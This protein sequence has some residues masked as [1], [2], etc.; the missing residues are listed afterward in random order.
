MS[1]RRGKAE[2]AWNA[3][4]LLAEPKQLGSPADRASLVRFGIDTM[5]SDQAPTMSLSDIVVQVVLA[6]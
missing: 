6:K 5:Q 4:P 3:R 1:A 2:P